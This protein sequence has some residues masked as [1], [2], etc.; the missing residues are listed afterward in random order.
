VANNEP[1]FCNKKQRMYHLG[2][3]LGRIC[4]IP[5]ERIASNSGVPH[6]RVRRVDRLLLCLTNE[7][8]HAVLVDGSDGKRFTPVICKVE[9][10]G[11]LMDLFRV[12]QFDKFIHFAAQVRCVF[13]ST[14]DFRISRATLW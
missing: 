4:R 5:G 8:W 10:P 12:H 1:T 9:D 7:A 2:H 13:R 14:T 6:R 11:L 3:R